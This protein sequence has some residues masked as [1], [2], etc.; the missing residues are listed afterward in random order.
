VVTDQTSAHDPLNGYVPQGLTLAEATNCANRILGNMCAG[1]RD[2]GGACGRDAGVAA[3]GAVAF[4]YG[5]NI[6]RFAFDAGAL[7]RS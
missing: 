4:D 6:R 5:N 3:G 1:R 2:Y 7:M